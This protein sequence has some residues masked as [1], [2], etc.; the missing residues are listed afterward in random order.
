VIVKPKWLDN[1]RHAWKLPDPNKKP[2]KRDYGWLPSKGLPGKLSGWIVEGGKETYCK[3]LEKWKK[4]N[5]EKVE[6]NKPRKGSG[7][8]AK[9]KKKKRGR[10]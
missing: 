2:V 4:E 5:T 8:K 10:K 3:A 1:V 9:G 6:K 7:V